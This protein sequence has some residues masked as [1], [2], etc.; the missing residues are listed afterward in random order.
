MKKNRPEN[1]LFVKILATVLLLLATSAGAFAQQTVE[2]KGRAIDES[3]NPV[4]GATVVVAGT[5]VGTL[6]DV[7]GNFTLKAREGEELE[8]SF[9]GMKAQKVKASSEF[10]TVTLGTEAIMIDQAVV[11]GYGTAQKRDLTGSIVNVKAEEIANRPSS[12]PL[13]SLQGRIAGVQ[14]TNTGRAGQDPEIRIR[15][16]NSINGFSPLYVVDGMFTDN[17][18][19]LNA[20]DIASFEILKDPS[21]LA[22]FGV[23]GANGVI[24]ITTK[25]AKQGEAVVNINQS[26]GVKHVGHRLSLTNAAQFRELFNEQTVNMD[27]DPFDYTH[28]T[29]DTDWQDAIFQNAVIS[30][31]TAS[32]MGSGEKHNFYLGVGYTYEQGNIKNEEMQ[33]VTFNFSD[34]YRMKDWVKFGV[35]LNGAYMMPA[36]AKDV[37]SAVQ[38]VPIAPIF[39]A[40]TGGYYKMPSFQ[41]PQLANPMIEVDRFANHNIAQNYRMGGNV[42]GEINFLPSLKF[43]AAFALDYQSNNNR[44]FRPVMFEYD[45]TID[46][47]APRSEIQSLSQTKS[48][49]L[50]AQQDYILTFQKTFAQK[51]ALTLMA[52]FSTNYT[53]FESLTAGRSQNINSADII[54]PEDPDKWWISSIGDISSATNS[55]QQYKR[56]TMSYMFRALY[57]YDHKYLLNLSYRRDGASVFKYSGNT[58]DDFYSIG[59][60]W[61]VSEEDFM[62]RQNFINY[63]KVKGSYGVLGNQN[64]GSAGGFYPS[65]PTLNSSNA[66]FGDNIISS[67]SQAYLA[68]DLRWERTKSWEAGLEMMVLKNR[69]H[70]DVTYYNKQTEDLICYLEKFMGAQDGLINSGKIRNRGFE[71]AASWSDK[72]GKD[73]TY[74]LSANLTT[75]D[76]KVLELGKN[77]HEGSRNV[78]VS[79]P[80][81]PIGYFYGYE[82]VG[83][84][85]NEADIARSPKNSLAAPAPGDLK[86]R[87]VDGNGLI[88]DADRTMIGNPTPDFTYGYSLNLGYRNF[89]LGLDFQGVYGNEIYNAGFMTSFAQY[90]YPAKRLGRW[91]GEGTS[92]WEPI[93]DSGRALQKE[94]SSYY[95]EDGSYLRLRNI[96]LGYRF[97]DRIIRKLRLKGLRLYMNVENVATWAHNTGYTPEIGGSALAFGIDDGY[98]YPMP[99]TITFG[100]NVTF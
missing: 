93:L 40:K 35:Q 51:H 25:K 39:D 28:Y 100:V 64:I 4:L 38:A 41:S 91:R 8:V 65:F 57:H 95:I 94:N 11:I 17:I 71:L 82:V 10:L 48:N 46:K 26:V 69:L 23:R 75:I 33:K 6:T 86:F 68:T 66:I 34:E 72:I 7:D 47:I 84:Y 61:V 70:L 18:G 21:S 32:V 90:N 30:Q 49:T 76:N 22:I 63:L 60:G 24:I 37:T 92:N 87:D 31:T 58:W 14:I 54:I 78:A 96:Q 27:G 88:N 56:F 89:D 1:C 19:F 3:G 50:N 9:V 55:G 81:M 45:P 62:K 80:G 83:V 15:G 73:F 85:Q 43:R 98:T 16:T 44:L 13:A 79:M 36:D 99:T 77:Y 74:S 12:N 42:W 20:N 97:G 67:Y 53:Q 2:V 52:G 5:S 29:A 59:A